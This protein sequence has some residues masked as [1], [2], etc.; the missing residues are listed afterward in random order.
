MMMTEG[1]LRTRVGLYV[2]ALHVILISLP[3]VLLMFNGFR[4]DQATTVL[5][6]TMPLFAGYTSVIVKFFSD[7]RHEDLYVNMSRHAARPFVILSFLF[8][9]LFCIFLC[10]I[11]LLMA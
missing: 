5:A 11:M 8:P 10:T 6:M 9:T 1:V 2:I 4:F 3:I 7:N